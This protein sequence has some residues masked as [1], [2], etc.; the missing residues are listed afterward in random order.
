MGSALGGICSQGGLF[1]GVPGGDPRDGY[2]C[3][4]YASY[5]NAFLYIVDFKQIF[6]GS[7]RVTLVVT[8]SVFGPSAKSRD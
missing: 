4:W 1:P 5:W 7:L 2:C 3:R 8:L 6:G